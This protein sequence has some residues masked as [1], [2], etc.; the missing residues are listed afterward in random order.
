MPAL[1][2]R[3]NFVRANGPDPESGYW[4]YLAA[5]LRGAGLNVDRTPLRGITW[6]QMDPVLFIGG[7]D[8]ELIS[9]LKMD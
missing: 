3:A 1:R 4:R 9:G 2:R 5:R 6:E 7:T 8:T